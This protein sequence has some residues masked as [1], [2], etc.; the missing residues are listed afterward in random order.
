MLQYHSRSLLVALLL[1]TIGVSVVIAQVLRC[2]GTR[3]ATD[4]ST[5]L[6]A[7]QDN[8]LKSGPGA[9]PPEIFENAKKYIEAYNRHDVKAL[10][11]LFTKDCVIIEVD[12]DTING[13][14]E[15]KE[16][17]KDEFADTPQ[18]KISLDL[19]DI[20]LI[21]PEVAVEQGKTTFFPDGKTATRVTQYEVIHIKVGQR[22]LVSRVRSFNP[23]SLTPYDYLRE[24][25]WMVGDWIDE[26]PDSLV[27]TSFAWDENKAF[28]LQK[29]VVKIKGQKVLQ[30]SE[31]IGWDPVAKHIRSWIFDSQGG[32]GERHWTYIDNSW[33]ITAKGTRPDGDIMTATNQLTRLSDERMRIASVDRIIGD[34]RMPNQVVIAVRKP[35]APKK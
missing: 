7:L 21:S 34:E 25:E 27:E 22:W 6:A 12:G 24:L 28:L 17:F 15:L 4:Q 19:Q 13:L 9:A 30:G 23:E 20:R 2:L 18:S 26:G 3:P 14:K 1:P 16:D 5:V 31:R 35:P 29:F 8:E 11:D 33:F 10:L 32:F